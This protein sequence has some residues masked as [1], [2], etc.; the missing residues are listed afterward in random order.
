M[1]PIRKSPL[2]LLLANVEV[3]LENLNSVADQH[4]LEWKDIFHEALVFAF[5]AEFHHPLHA[6]PIVP[7]PIEQNQFLRSGQMRHVA[8]EVPR[9]TVTVS[10]LA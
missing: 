7:A 2:L 3:V 6:R 4:V 5:G 8:L 9:G 1:S 10:W